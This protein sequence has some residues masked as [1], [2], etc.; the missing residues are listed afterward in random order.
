MK[1][2]ISL[3]SITRPV[4]IFFARFHV[5]IY[6]FTVI[7]GVSVATFALIQLVAQPT[8]D[9]QSG[10]S[11]GFDTDTISRIKS[12]DTAGSNNLSLPP[13]R[14]NPLTD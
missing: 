5:L 3:S 14:I 12:L 11:S 4:S 6:T 7:V 1:G 8:L 13:G 9:E 2:S 10:V